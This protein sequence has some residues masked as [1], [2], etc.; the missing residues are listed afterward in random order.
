MSKNSLS[1]AWA[2]AIVSTASIVALLP[3]AIFGIP[4][5]HDLPSHLR[6]AIPLYD[7]ISSGRFH[8]G[9]VAQANG[10]F[11]DAGVRF[12]PPA[13]YYL[14][15]GTLAA[16]GS[17]Y[18]GILVGFILLTVLG[19]FGVYLWARCF[20]QRPT[21]IVAAV[22]YAFI[23]YRIN[24]FYG[25]SLLAEYA[26]ASVLPF[27]FAFVARVCRNRELTDVLGLATAFAFILLTNLPVAVIA[28]ISLLLYALLNIELK[29]FWSTIGGLSLAVF[30]SLV[31]SAF[32]W[33]T[34]VAELSWMKNSP[35][36]PNA[37]LDS[38]F[39]YRRNFV[40][41]PFSLS[42]QNSW[43]AAMLTLAMLAMAVAPV[44]VVISPYRRKLGQG[45]KAVLV[46]LAFSL[47][48]ASDFSRPVWAVIPKLKE[49]QFP[50]R[51]LVVTSSVIPLLTAASIPFWQEQWRGRFRWAT[52]LVVG[53]VLISLSY[54]VARMRQANYLP[55][56]EFSSASNAA[57]S[58][59]SGD[60]WLPVWVNRRPS[61]M[62]SQVEASGRSTS[63]KS[64]ESQHKDFSV[65]SG[66]AQEIRVHT[67]YYPHWVARSAG[68]TLSTRPDVD[69]SLLIFVPSEFTNVQLDFQE[70]AR[71]R[72][73]LIVS[74]LGWLLIG[75]FLLVTVARRS[76]T[77]DRLGESLLQA[78]DE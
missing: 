42:N 64:W 57:F 71:T 21:A 60:Y 77:K 36:I 61:S 27:A 23:P 11:G 18:D 6:F 17:W 55:R 62:V 63:I 31:A 53:M 54:S 74:G 12:Y 4:A 69:G 8:A 65:E 67:F 75:G 43:L 50:W 49:I 58:E 34:M 73:A 13:L 51:W 24:E 32:Y 78:S 33:V 41:S 9:W 1:R 59:N 48:M 14:L 2:A 56:F 38:Y 28:S 70:P 47:F 66:P 15:A 16:F 39:D 40:L 76:K 37:D 5:G 45:L 30:L 10:G 29:V 72:I 22:L 35:I 46:L 68:A 19:A 26:A 52:I 20:V 7:A 44:V 25:A 3:A